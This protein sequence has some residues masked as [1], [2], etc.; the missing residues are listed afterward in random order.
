[1]PWKFRQSIT[2]RQRSRFWSSGIC[3][4][5][6]ACQG[7]LWWI[8]PTQRQTGSHPQQFAFCF[9][10]A[11]VVA[12]LWS[13][14]HFLLVV[15]V[16]LSFLKKRWLPG[17]CVCSMTLFMLLQQLT[18]SLLQKSNK[19]SLHHVISC[20]ACDC[21][22]SSQIMFNL[23]WAAWIRLLSSQIIYFFNRGIRLLSTLLKPLIVPRQ[24]FLCRGFR[25]LVHTLL[26]LLFNTSGCP[27]NW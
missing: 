11:N 18:S 14:C 3:F 15:W 26:A 19:T 27:P 20:T 21:Y 24:T 17:A 23:I 1:M 16:H 10:H 25:S 6:N 7:L 5:L 22:Y 13:S 2:A 8:P 12:T 9:L 4:K